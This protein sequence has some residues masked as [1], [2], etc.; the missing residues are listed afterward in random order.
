MHRCEQVWD[1]A[2]HAA[3]V[4]RML[5]TRVVACMA[6]S[7]ALA[8]QSHLQNYYSRKKK[9]EMLPGP[10]VCWR[11]VLEAAGFAAIA[12]LWTGNLQTRPPH[13]APVA[14][15]GLATTHMCHTA[16]KPTARVPRPDPW[17]R[18]APAPG[19]GP[20]TRRGVKKGPH[21][22]TTTRVQPVPAASP[23]PRVG[24]AGLARSWWEPR[25]PPEPPAVV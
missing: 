19:Q 1:V 20:P 16:A 21:F 15:S 18:R 23:S 2:S 8:Q 9:G 3:Y 25:G 11:V 4:L 14:M 6:A 7:S 24:F 5:C 10:G 22:E 17:S 12:L 13:Q